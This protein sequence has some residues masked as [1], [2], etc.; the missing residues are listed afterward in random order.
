MKPNLST[1]F[2]QLLFGALIQAIFLRGAARLIVKV[3][4][5]Y[6][7]AYWLSFAVLFAGIVVSLA[8][9]YIPLVRPAQ[10]AVQLLLQFTG[11]AL[12]GGILY[13]RHVEYADT[14]QIGLKKGFLVSITQVGLLIGV[15]TVLVGG[16]FLIGYSY[17]KM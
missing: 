5:P 11:M 10:I 9:F 12:A 16:I 6:G 8:S 13:S 4:V 3:K 14:Q 15:L 1:L 2:P 7:R 17:S